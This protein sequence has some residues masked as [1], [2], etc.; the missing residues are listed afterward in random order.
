MRISGESDRRAPRRPRPSPSRAWARSFADRNA[1]TG[2]T[3]R[4]QRGPVS[5]SGSRRASNPTSKPPWTAR[6][7]R[8][9]LV[10]PVMNAVSGDMSYRAPACAARYVSGTQMRAPTTAAPSA[11]VK[12]PKRKVSEGAA[13]ANM[14]GAEDA[15]EDM[16]DDG[17]LLLHSVVR[18]RGASTAPYPQETL[19]RGVLPGFFLAPIPRYRVHLNQMKG[20][21]HAHR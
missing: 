16:G 8:P 18:G 6:Q 10:S 15:D 20:R 3:S 7:V 19:G 12:R 13:P 1:P 2:A 9:P 21:A 17:L 4:C 5:E 14:D 11:P